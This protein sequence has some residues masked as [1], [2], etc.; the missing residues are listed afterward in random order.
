MM[1]KFWRFVVAPT[2]Y[3]TNAIALKFFPDLSIPLKVDRFKGFA[4]R[5]DI[6]GSVTN[7]M[8]GCKLAR[9]ALNRKVI[10]K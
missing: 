10:E 6:D 2:G 3:T 1:L 8:S 5:T 7:Y 9:L 4:N